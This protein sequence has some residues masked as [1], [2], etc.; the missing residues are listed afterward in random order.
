MGYDGTE[1]LDTNFLVYGVVEDRLWSVWSDSDPLKSNLAPGLSLI[2]HDLRII[3][4]DDESNYSLCSCD[5]D[6]NEGKGPYTASE[7]KY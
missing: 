2:I 6:I 7:W 5:I 3:S 4:T 1:W